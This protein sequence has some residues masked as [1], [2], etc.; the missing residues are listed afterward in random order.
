MIKIVIQLLILFFL[1]TVIP[2]VSAEEI[3]PRAG[4][5]LI[6]VGEDKN[7]PPRPR[8]KRFPT[9]E[10]R[11]EYQQFLRRSSRVDAELKTEDATDKSAEVSSK[12]TT[13]N[14]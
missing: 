9:D 6:Y 1:L 7:V 2:A 11:E 13:P 5:S 8:T 4:G 3:P 12:K 14:Q 10:A